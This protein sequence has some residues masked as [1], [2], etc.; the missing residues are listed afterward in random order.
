M[1]YLRQGI[2]AGDADSAEDA[3]PA[4]EVLEKRLADADR[5][6]AEQ[7][8]DDPA[9]RCELLLERG[10]LLLDLERNDEAWQTASEAFDLAHG[11]ALWE[12]AVQAGD[13]MYQAEQEDSVKA[14]AHAVWLGVTFPIDP[15]VSVAVLERMVDAM[16]EGV[17]GAAVTAAA[18]RFIA[19][20]RAE[21]QAHED[22]L[23]FTTQLLGRV[24]RAH[25]GIEDQE[26][27][28]TWVE[29]YELDNPDTFLPQLAQVIDALVPAD[30]WWIDRE[31]LRA[32]IPE[33]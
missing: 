10:A 23:F 4:T 16:P 31:A 2:Y 3:I 26:T 7:S 6:L 8:G 13:Q 32:S 20:M 33:S 19:D 12:Q 22:L 14:L 21:G 17:D 24:A 1:S 5:R 28:E 9:K 25:R 29:F 15:E 27:F 18:A 30:E 11:N